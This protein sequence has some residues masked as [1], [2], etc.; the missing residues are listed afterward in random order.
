[1]ILDVLKY[2]GRVEQ[3]QCPSPRLAQEYMS[4]CIFQLIFLMQL[5]KSLHIKAFAKGATQKHYL[6][7]DI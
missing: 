2:G 3:P 6:D 5:S 7:L 1:M 4:S